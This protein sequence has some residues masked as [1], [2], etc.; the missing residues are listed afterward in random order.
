MAGSRRLSRALQSAGGVRP[1]ADLSRVA[2]RRGGQTI[3]IDVRPAISG[4][5]YSD[6]LLLEGDQIEVASRGC[7]QEALVVPSSITTPGVKVF[8]SNLSQPA[9]AN[10]LSAIGK[11]TR[12]LRYGTRFLQAIVGMN[13]MAARSSP[14]PAARRCCSRA[15]RSPGN[16]SS[17]SDGG[18]LLRRAD[19][20]DYDPFII[21]GR[22]TRL[23]RFGGDERRR[24]RPR[25]RRDHGGGGAGRAVACGRP[26]SGVGG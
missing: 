22:R 16:R 24:D 9:D 2:V 21:A 3:T 20:D 23:L 19:R 12:E 11:D 26:R 13:C 15:T 1:D 17:S 6:L 10:A 14:M 25:L 8:M 5:P 4:R 18:D 7:F